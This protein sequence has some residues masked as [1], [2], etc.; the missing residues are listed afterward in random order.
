[1]N[2]H[3]FH[4]FITQG[5]DVAYEKNGETFYEKIYPFD[6][7]NIDNNDFL[8]VNQFTVIEGE[9]HRRPDIV[10]FVN[11]IPVVVVELKRPDEHTDDTDLIEEA[12]DQFQTYMAEIP[13]LLRFN[14][15]LIT[16]D[17]QEA[18][19]GTITAPLNY[20]VPWKHDKDTDFSVEPEIDTIING[21]LQPE[22]LMDI[23]RNFVLFED[24]NGVLLKKLAR[25]HQY[26]A[27]NKAISSTRR[28]VN[29]E[30][31][32]R[33]GVVWHTTGAGKSI[34]MVFYAQKITH[35][36]SL[37]NSTLVVI[38]D[39]NDLDD[40]LF[41]TFSRCM[42][43]IGQ[44]PIQAVDSQD[45]MDKLS[46]KSGGIIFTT[47]QKFSSD[48]D[49]YPLLSE[50]RNIIVMADE[51]HRS[52]YGLKAK[53]DSK[54]G[55]KSYG[56]AKYLRDA[57]PNASFIGFTGTP[58][59]LSDKSTKAIFGEYIDIYDIEQSLKDNV[60]V[61]ISYE[62][63]LSDLRIL[64]NDMEKLDSKF[65]D[66][67]A[68]E[69]SERI[70][71]L[72]TKEASVE[73][74]LTT[75]ENMHKIASDIVTH[76]ESRMDAMEGKA[77]TV[78]MSRDMAAQLH[79]AI[80]DIRPD[81]YDESDSKGQIKVI[82]TGKASDTHLQ[83]HIRSKQRQKQIQQRM[84]DPE[85]PL[86]MVIVCD[87]WLTGFDVPCLTTMYFLKYLRRHNIIQAISRVNRVYLD[88]P[89]GLIV[90]Y[91]GILYDLKRALKDYTD[92]GGKGL[93]AEDQQI[94]VDY[95]Q[96]TYE[97]ITAML[98]GFD[99]KRVFDVPAGEKLGII[100]EGADFI[101]QKDVMINREIELKKHP[102]EDRDYHRKHFIK[103]TTELSHA[104]ALASPQPETELIRDELGYFQSV[105]SVLIS[106]ERKKK[107]YKSTKELKTAV[108]QLVKDTVKAGEIIDVFD[109]MGMKK[110]SVDIFDEKF[111]KEIKN[112]PQ[113][114]LAA[115]LLQKLLN[116]K[117]KAYSKRNITRG[118]FSPKNCRNQSI[119]TETR[120][121]PI[122]Q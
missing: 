103:F 28:A 70:D 106:I 16:S 9:H 36:I 57:I 12:Y 60:T 7:D 98:H 49:Q 20:F 44:T 113:K 35:D 111:L 38:T 81:W 37:E 74:I 77:M 82:I 108:R 26:Y 52:Q 18:R 53:F 91:V 115:E 58:V 69:D 47:L 117:I 25:Y 23:V 40:Q 31:N 33:C 112:M 64:P 4:K 110:E 8:A 39:R 27:V 95:M 19:S 84:K 107:G 48:E 121:S 10:L 65:E 56:F 78:T 62:S 29:P 90:D 61:P 67:T 109:V 88:K 86:K 6:F 100:R 96:E 55:E 93:L 73:A 80:I 79:D 105:K 75:P 94:A 66:I 21:M 5:I 101:L 114:N 13:G 87:M 76:F 102:K 32:K 71:Q 1:M 11:G 99:Y 42:D 68:G 3:E 89:G 17:G 97:Q 51:A 45:L 2:N 119:P 85:D 50:R 83:E 92:S 72:K 34:E 122:L 43:Y 15:I 120:T 116:D 46:R 30:G 14:E 22:V 41:D 59:E 54:T 63:R 24:E 104:F 118:S